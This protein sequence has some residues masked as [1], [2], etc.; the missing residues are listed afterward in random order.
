MS[1]TESDS[2]ASTTTTRPVGEANCPIERRLAEI[3]RRSAAEEARLGLGPLVGDDEVASEA[4]R[5]QDLPPSAFRLLPP[6]E[7]EASA[8]LLSQWALRLQRAHNEMDSR[9]RWAYEATNRLV[10][11][12]IPGYKGFSFEER[13][14]QAVCDSPTAQKL[15]KVHLEARGR[16]ER[17][18]YLAARAAEMA[19]M[20]RPCGRRGE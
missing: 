20:M 12:E 5:L 14:G 17:L 10:A 13:R 4:K 18:S 8:Y 16:A 1:L 7:R 2:S 19:K 9:A 15:D 11:K 6:A 3:E